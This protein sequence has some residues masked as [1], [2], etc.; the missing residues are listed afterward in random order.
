MKNNLEGVTFPCPVR[1]VKGQATHPNRIGVAVEYVPCDYV[2]VMLDGGGCLD[3]HRD[4]VEPIP[5]HLK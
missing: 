3:F 1:M 2:R 5:E 4:E